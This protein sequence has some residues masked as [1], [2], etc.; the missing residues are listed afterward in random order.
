MP[1]IGTLPTL[2][3]LESNPL[4]AMST[5]PAHQ[6]SISSPPTR[7]YFAYGSNLCLNQMS[8]RCPTAVYQAFGIL[9][10][11][12]WKIGPRGFANVISSTSVSNLLENS[13]VCEPIVCGALY[14]LLPGDEAALDLAEQ[15]PS[16]YI[17]QNMSIE[18]LFVA[19]GVVSDIK[20][21]KTVSALVYMNV[22]ETGDGICN[23]EYG[24]RLN[25]SIRDG[26]QTVESHGGANTALESIW[27]RVVLV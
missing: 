19:D 20:L 11:Y 25:R 17:K 9:H 27:N 15:V 6:S 3:E 13:K 4:D 21:G 23:D 18:V 22:E 16:V 14:T 5:L 7:F 26:V 12:E 10:D 24:V 8:C 1:S 2:L